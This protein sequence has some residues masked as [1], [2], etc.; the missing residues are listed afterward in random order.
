MFT[1]VHFDAEKIPLKASQVDFTKLGAEFVILDAEGRVL[2]GLN[3]TAARVWELIDGQ[4]SVAQIAGCLAAEFRISAE[5]ALQDVDDFI[6]QLVS[7]RL[8]MLD[9]V[10]SSSTGGQR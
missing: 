4:R 1:N 6:S 8:L 2:R 3:P 7:K 9:G 10:G 5:R